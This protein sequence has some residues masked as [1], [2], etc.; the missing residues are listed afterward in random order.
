MEHFRMSCP[1]LD[2]IT[3]DN[4]DQ[5]AAKYRLI[6]SNSVFL[7]EPAVRRRK[8]GLVSSVMPLCRM[9]GER[10]VN[11]FRKRSPVCGKINDACRSLKT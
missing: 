4:Q 6:S 8:S 2:D 1:S 3:K 5:A 7:R 10:S 11:V 9:E